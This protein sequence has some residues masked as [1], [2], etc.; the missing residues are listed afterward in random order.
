MILGDVWGFLGLFWGPE[1]LFW[2]LRVI[3][4]DLGLTLGSFIIWGHLGSFWGQFWDVGVRLRVLA[5]PFRGSL[6]RSGG[7]LCLLG[8]FGVILGYLGG[9]FG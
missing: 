6:G 2:V 1:D 8:V 3:L 5:R 7:F 4:V 9:A